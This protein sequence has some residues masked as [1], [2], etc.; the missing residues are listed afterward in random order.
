MGELVKGDVFFLPKGWKGRWDVLEDMEKFYVIMG[1]SDE[2]FAEQSASIVEPL[3][4]LLA[5]VKPGRPFGERVDAATKHAALVERPGLSVGV[6]RCPPTSRWEETEG[7]ADVVTIMLGGKLN[8]IDMDG[9][10]HALVKDDV[11]F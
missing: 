7:S 3:G 8:L 10:S 2:V 9:R 6:Y 5:R 4:A 11:F 1:R